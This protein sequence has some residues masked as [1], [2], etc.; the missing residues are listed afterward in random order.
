[1]LEGI[2]ILLV[3]I[4]C[5]LLSVG[6]LWYVHGAMCKSKRRWR[7]LDRIVD[8]RIAELNARRSR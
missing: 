6:C 3:G 1:M 4:G 2:V 5:S 8:A 7:D